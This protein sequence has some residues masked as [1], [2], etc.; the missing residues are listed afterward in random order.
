MRFDAGA[1]VALARWQ[2]FLA[3]ID[4]RHASVRAEAAA[5]GGAFIATIAADGD[6]APLSHQLMAVNTRLMALEA[7]IDEAWHAKVHDAFIAEGADYD[8]CIEMHGVGRQ[9][10]DRLDEARA[11]LETSLMAEF[12]T[13]RF[14]HVLVRR[15]GAVCGTCG[16]VLLAPVALRSFTLTCG[17]CGQRSTLAPGDDL[18]MVAAIAAHPIAQQVALPQWRDMRRA[19]ATLGAQRPPRP[20]FLIQAAEVTQLAYWRVYFAARAAFEPI[21]ARDPDLEIRARME[22]WYRSH[23]EFEEAWVAAGRPRAPIG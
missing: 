16:A 9:V 8:A 20:L 18:R 13:A 19:L 1:S 7:M 14:A 11:E 4:G 3:Q 17:A 12:A 21:L 2:S 5:S 15:G 10:G 6:A 22:P 23:A